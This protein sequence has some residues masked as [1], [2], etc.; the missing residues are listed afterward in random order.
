MADPILSDFI[1]RMSAAF[2]PEKAAGIDATIQLK[3]T[4]DQPGEYYMTIKDSKCTVSQ[5]QASSPRLT[6]TADRGDLVKIFSGQ[7]DGMQAF[8]K[9]KIRIA[10]DMTLA[11]KLLQLFKMR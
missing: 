1:D 10:G 11:L 9:G 8:L 3:L 7:M 2:I 5:G 6:A 4:G